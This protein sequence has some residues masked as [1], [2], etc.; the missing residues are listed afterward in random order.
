MRILNLHTHYQQPGGEDSSFAAEVAVLQER[1]HLVFPLVFHNKALEGLPPW[2]QAGLTLWNQEAY[3]RVREAI[4]E[5]RPDILHVH[6][7]FPLASPAVIHAAKAEGVPVVMSLHNYRLLCV[8]G[9]FF[10]EG[11][12]CEACLGRLPWR[13]LPRSAASGRRRYYSG[14]STWSSWAP[15]SSPFPRQLGR[16]DAGP[17]APSGAPGFSCPP[18]CRLRWR[19]GQ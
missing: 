6:N 18:S 2:R 5:H 11:R 14:P 8:N 3:Q 12:V 9:L 7:T 17:S 15:V 4:R 16:R 1:G 19:P 10:R 13:G